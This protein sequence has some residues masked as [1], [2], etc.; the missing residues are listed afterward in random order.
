M[1]KGIPMLTRHST[2]GRRLPLA[3]DRSVRRTDQDGHLHVERCILSAAVVSDYLGR[4]IPDSAALGFSPDRTYRLYRDAD[5]LREAAPSLRGK[6]ILIEHQ[7]ISAADHPH[8]QVVGSVGSDV[9]FDAPNLVGSLSFWAPEAIKAIE[10]GSMRSVSAGYRY[11][12]IRQ[13]GSISGQAYDGI[14]RDISF[15]H[16]ALCDTPRVP[17]AVIGDALPAQLKENTNMADTISDLLMQRNA[18]LNDP[19]STDT[20][21]FNRD[22]LDRLDA[23]LTDGKSS[24]AMD[25]RRARQS[26]PA[27]TG[28]RSGPDRLNGV[29]G[30]LSRIKVI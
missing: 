18:Y 23:V 11:R 16:L 29:L 20:E 7:P 28:W 24:P 6:P 2:H 14:M 1:T 10:N 9:Q 19:S 4:E 13:S 26:A 5:A 30:P 27:S 3:Y 15:N 8:S 22:W 21:S 12:A 17:A 25:A